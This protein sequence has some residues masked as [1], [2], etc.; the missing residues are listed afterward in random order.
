MMM[1]LVAPLRPVDNGRGY[2]VGSLVRVLRICLRAAC[3]A[4]TVLW[5]VLWLLYPTTPGSTFKEDVTKNVYSS[6]FGSS[7]T[8]M[9][10]SLAVWSCFPSDRSL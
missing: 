8:D 1:K 3:W 6:F 4:V 2:G 10:L 9:T 5:L 7:G